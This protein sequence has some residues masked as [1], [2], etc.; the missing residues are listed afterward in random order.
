MPHAPV[1]SFF[2]ATWTLLLASLMGCASNPQKRPDELPP[3]PPPPS[4]STPLPQTNY[5]LSAAKDTKSWRARLMG[6]SLMSAP[7]L[8]PG[9]KE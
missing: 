8:K 4:L 9:H 1:K 5:S 2:V 7:F 6:T 3:L